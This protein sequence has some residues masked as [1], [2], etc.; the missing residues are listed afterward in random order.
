MAGRLVI[1]PTPIG[2]LGDMTLRTL[3]ELRA[4]DVVCA[5][6]TRVTGKLLAHFGIEK[7]LERL[8]EATITRQATHVAERVAAGEVIAFCSDAGMPGVSDPGARLI[9]AAQQAGCDV[10]VLPGA[11]A[12]STAYVASGFNNPRYYFGGFFPRKAG[13]RH[14]VLEGLKSLDAVLVFYESPRRIADALSVVAEVLPHREVAVCRELTKLHEEVFRAS[15]SD[16]AAEFARRD[17]EEGVRGEIA[18]VIGP[19]TADEEQASAE[20]SAASA[21]ERAAELLSAG[22]LSR[23]DIVR[24]L[25]DEF[26]ISR[27]EAYELVHGA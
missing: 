7:R 22:E 8:D 25:R 13:E 23:K 21:A 11:S 24:T 17:A 2:N 9:E 6:D 14:A 26:G 15:A 4:A 1:C 18:L 27:N 10:V 3:E 12:A 16:A 5:E 20:E 19:P